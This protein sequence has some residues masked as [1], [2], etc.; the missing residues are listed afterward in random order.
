M[1]R[2]SRILFACLS[3][4]V[5]TA[6]CSGPG[7]QQYS[8]ANQNA[9]VY[10]ADEFNRASPTFARE[11]EE[12]DSVTICYNKYGT[13]PVIIANMATEECK[14]FNKKAEFVRQSLSVCPLF[15]PVAAIY[16]CVGGK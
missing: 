7:G 13:K 4:A 12:I 14:K 11:P 5:L 2:A 6:A 8:Q 1:V 10:H 3:V 16:D 9:Y 15:T